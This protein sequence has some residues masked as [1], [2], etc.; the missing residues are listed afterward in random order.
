M[1]EQVHKIIKKLLLS[2]NRR[3]DFLLNHLKLSRKLAWHVVS[4][5][6]DMQECNLC[7]LLKICVSASMQ[8]T[9]YDLLYYAVL[10]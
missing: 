8:Y 2:N 10:L 3:F 4:N 9:F 1:L 7:S 5:I 6:K